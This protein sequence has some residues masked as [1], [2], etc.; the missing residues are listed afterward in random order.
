[1][2]PRPHRVVIYGKLFS[3]LHCWPCY[4]G[5]LRVCVS[6]EGMVESVCVCVCVCVGGMVESVC[7]C[8]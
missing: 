7:V 8:V 3:S 1:M 4:I 6:L 2:S 5:M